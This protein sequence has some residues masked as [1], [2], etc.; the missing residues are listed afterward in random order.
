MLEKQK[1]PQKPIST[2]IVV[3]PM[4]FHWRGLKPYFKDES[5]KVFFIDGGLSHIDK[6][7]KDAPLLLKTSTSMGDGDSSKRPMKFKKTDQSL[8]D[9]AFFLKY[10]TSKPA[11][12]QYVFVGFLGGRRDHELFN[13][14]EL[15]KFTRKLKQK[16]TPTIHLE[17]KIAFYP[18]GSHE[19]NIKGIFSIASFENTRIKITGSCQY[20][21]KKWLKLE[22]LSSK[23]LSN[24]GDGLIHI[25]T[26]APIAVFFD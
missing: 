24:L 2:C 7:K 18:K 21:F 6:F 23:G 19:I 16:P 8:S 12:E 13:L 5:T 25:Q 26:E 17:D 9:L 15:A 14:G 11:F 20:Q 10:I 4:P 3:G 22:C 1:H